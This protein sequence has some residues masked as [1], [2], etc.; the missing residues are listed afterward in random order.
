M[1]ALNITGTALIVIGSNED[2]YNAYLSARNLANVAMVTADNMSV[3]DV[4][5]FDKLVMTEAAI[6]QVEEVLA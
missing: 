2:A 3:Y 1:E 4:L 6:A 5:A